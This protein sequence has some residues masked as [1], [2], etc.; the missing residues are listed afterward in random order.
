MH[1]LSESEYSFSSTTLWYEEW[2]AHGIVKRIGKSY[3]YCLTDSEHE[4]SA[5]MVIL[6]EKIFTP[7]FSGSFINGFLSRAN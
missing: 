1:A 6:N 2:I 5:S 7:A 4:I 3:T